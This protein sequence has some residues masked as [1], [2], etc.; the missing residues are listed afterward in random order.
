MKKKSICKSILLL[1][2][3]LLASCTSN[4]KNIE[5]TTTPHEKI[6]QPQIDLLGLYQG[7]QPS[8]F[9]K[10]EFGDD[11]LVF[12]KKVP[13]PSSDY[14]F[15]LKENGKASLQLTSL[16]DNTRY[17]YE[18]S[19]TINADDAEKLKITCKLSD[20]KTSNPTYTLVINKTNKAGLCK[21]DND[22][23]FSI[24]KVN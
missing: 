19:Y 17:F 1:P 10:N 21:G 14:K 6:T 13:V 16:E 24:K 9:M 2:I 22:P 18:G 20:G 8:Y 15:L 5:K 12:G 23:E 4:T 7:V 3:F 11:L